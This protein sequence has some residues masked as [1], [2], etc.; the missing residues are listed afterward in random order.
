[1]LSEID[2]RVRLAIYT[3]L[4]EGGIPLSAALASKLHVPRPQIYESYER[5]HTARA[6]VLDPHTRE[7]RMALPFSAVPTPF[8]VFAQGRTWFA[9]CAWDSF[10]IPSLVGCDAVLTTSCPDC[11]APIVHRVEQRRLADAHGVVHFAVP[12]AKWWD[13]IGYT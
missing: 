1:M 12:A 3:T 10:G 8:R 4:A 2:F 9:N 6:I 5:L 13:N 7:V 11:E